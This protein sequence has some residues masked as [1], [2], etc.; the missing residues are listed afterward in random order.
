MSER[1]R[2][3][4]IEKWQKIHWFAR[5]KKWDFFSYKMAFCIRFSFESML[6]LIRSFS[7]LRHHWIYFSQQFGFELRPQSYCWIAEKPESMNHV[8][9]LVYFTRWK[10][11][12]AA[13]QLVNTQ[14]FHR[15][16]I[17][18]ILF[19]RALEKNWK[20]FQES[21]SHY[22]T[23]FVANN[24]LDILFFCTIRWVATSSKPLRKYRKF[25]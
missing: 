6:H 23:W 9:L 10:N 25:Y 15:I 14:L 21:I 16:S 3:N 4:L 8:T 2:K 11:G 20:L 22:I 18:E 24:L 13:K 1:N 12:D 7:F 17:R 19:T 5:K